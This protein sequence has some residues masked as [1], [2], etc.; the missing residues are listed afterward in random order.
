MLGSVSWDD[1]DW[2]QVMD[3]DEDE[4]GDEVSNASDG[5]EDED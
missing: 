2:D 4:E 1:A 3:E 5:P